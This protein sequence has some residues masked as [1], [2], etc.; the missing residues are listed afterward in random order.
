MRTVSGAAGGGGTAATVGAAG[1]G[2]PAG[3]GFDGAPVVAVAA[4]RGP[5]AAGAAQPSSRAITTMGSHTRR[6]LSIPTLAPLLARQLVGAYLKV[7]T[8]P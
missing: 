4:G 7:V 6:R 3:A 5:V 2:K 8:K 1:P